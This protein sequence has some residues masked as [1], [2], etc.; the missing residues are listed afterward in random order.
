MSVGPWCGGHVGVDLGVEDEMSAGGVDLHI[1]VERESIQETDKKN[2][3]YTAQNFR[4][5]F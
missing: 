4:D 2:V 1:N 3:N 5:S